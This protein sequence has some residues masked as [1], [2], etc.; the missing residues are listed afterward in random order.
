MNNLYKYETLN[1]K[2]DFINFAIPII[3]LLSPIKESPNRKYDNKYFLICLIDFVMNRV[4]WNKYTGT[5]HYPIN[6]KYL[7]QVHNRWIRLN[8]YEEINKQLLNRYLKTGKEHK[9]KYQMIDSSFIANKGGSIKNNNFLLTDAVKKKILKSEN[10][11]KNSPKI[12]NNEK[13]LLLILIDTMEEK[14]ILK[15]PL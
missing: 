15:Y 8:I 3:D 6:G 4:S 7:N 10:S 13:H 9:L 5:I 14:N 12:N 2:F 1:K 11:I